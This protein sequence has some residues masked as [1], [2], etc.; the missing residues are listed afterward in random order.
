MN[1]FFAPTLEPINFA[2]VTPERVQEA[3]QRVK[4]D[5]Q[6]AKEAILASADDDQNGRLLKRDDMNF[7]IGRVLSPLYLLNETHPDAAI[8]EACQAAVQ[9]LFAF[10]N[11][12]ALDEALFQSLAAFQKRVDAGDVSLDPVAARFLEKEMDH[13]LKNGFALSAEDRAVLK[14][15]DDQLS[16]KELTFS[17]NISTANPTLRVPEAELDGLP[18]DFM[19]RYRTE[20]GDYELNTQSPC[21]MPVMTFAKS[22]SLRE[23]LYK[24]YTNRAY[25]EN[26]ELLKEILILRQK[27]TKLLGHDTY[28]QYK[29]DSVMAKTPATVWGFYE[30]LRDKIKKKAEQDYAKLCDFAGVDH[31]PVWD[32]MFV[33]NAL[34]EAAYQIDQ[35]QV[36]QYFPLENTL[37]GLFGLARQLYGIEIKRDDALPV[38]HPEVRGYEVCENGKRVGLFYLDFHPR[39]NKYSHAACFDIQSGKLQPDGRYATPFSAL[40]CNFTPPNETRPSLLT[41]REVETLFHEFG[42]LM[43]QILTTS[44]I[45]GFSG[46]SVMRDFVEM[47][48]QIME[49][50]VW[51]ADSLAKLSHHWETGESLPEDLINKL[52]AGRHLNSGIDAQQQMFYGAIDMTLHDRYDAADDAARP[53]TELVKELQREYTLF[54]PVPESHFEASFGHLIGYAAGYYGYLWSRVYADDMF[55]RFEQTGIFDRETGTAL[56]AEVLAMGNTREPM[57]LIQSFLGRQPNSDAFLSHLG[58][59]P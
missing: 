57:D 12:L 4:D 8:R 23:R 33:T 28:A 6:V 34:R 19:D 15:L 13:Y 11:G 54:N 44:P 40:V 32:R 27:R 36:K 2:A 20:D 49:H 53:I 58:L 1:P 50:W 48:S 51:Q 25:P 22:S 29:L 21:Y 17:K 14:E 41:H 59:A 43:H 30:D 52:I 3:A 26:N 42:H 24:L 45:S 37:A 18:D 5:V 46:T 55:S 7:A 39:E 47:P 38:W 10:L 56:R 16:E 31:I 35:E 9:D